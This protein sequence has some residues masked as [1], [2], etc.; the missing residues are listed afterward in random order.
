ME[1]RIK[2]ACDNAA[3]EPDPGYEVARILR[4]FADTTQ[5]AAAIGH[6]Y[7][8]RDING[9]SVGSAEF[10][11]EIDD[12]I[13]VANRIEARAKLVVEEHRGHFVSYLA[14]AL[15]NLAKALHHA[16]SRNR[17]KML[18]WFG[19]YLEEASRTSDVPGLE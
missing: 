4:E 18:R 12:V 8:L 16:D 13:R 14:D 5:I 6:K 17:V 10:V 19:P 1:L 3:F 7:V 2:I 9:N 15:K 11:G